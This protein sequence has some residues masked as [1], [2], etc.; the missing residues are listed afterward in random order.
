M[1]LITRSSTNLQVEIDARQH[2]W[3]SD[4]PLN[5]GGDDAG[6]TPY[7]LLMSA[8]GACTVMTVQMYARRKGWALTTVT[9]A[10]DT[11]KI[12]ARD[13]DDCMSDKDAKVDI[14]EMQ[15]TFEGDLTPEQRSRLTEIAHK[16]PVHRT[17][18]NEVKIR[19]QT[20]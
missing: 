3:R 2:Q 13:C 14:I 9:V 8:L 17:L 11:Y 19:V 5:D 7:E 16:C 1:Q 10:L 6:P 15:L 18:T 12:Y 4:E 20:I